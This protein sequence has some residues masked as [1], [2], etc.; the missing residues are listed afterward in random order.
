MARL[1][2]CPNCEDQIR[3]PE[4]PRKSDVRRYCLKCSADTG[5]LVERVVP[6]L[7]RRRA[8]ALVDRKVKAQ[9]ARERERE[10]ERKRWSRTL[11]TASG[12]EIEVDILGEFKRV[13]RLP[14]FTGLAK[15]PP[16]L[17]LM[18][19]RYGVSGQA[20]GWHI[21]LRIPERAEA[22]DALETLVHEV[23]HAWCERHGR[24]SH[25]EFFK[26]ALSRAC[27]QYFPGLGRVG[28]WS[29][30]Q[31]YD[32]DWKIRARMRELR[33]LDNWRDKR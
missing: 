11:I 28:G 23:C 6:A 16:S 30:N 5:H 31:A 3:A 21:N 15:R 25:D 14:Q 1:W 4:R 2:R 17:N 18:R 33:V 13:C 29:N 22:E 24:H 27:E 12:E 19:S 32:L 8:Q 26:Q 9:T 20:W 7:E 10:A